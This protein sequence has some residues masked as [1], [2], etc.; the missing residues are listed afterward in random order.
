MA[1]QRRNRRGGIESRWHKTVY[2]TGP[3]G[4]KTKKQVKS[5]RYG[6]GK[7]WLARYVDDHGNEHTKSFDRKVDAQHWLDGQMSSLVHGNHVAPSAGRELIRDAG[8]RWLESQG[9]LKETTDSSRRFT[10]HIHVEPYWG[11]LAIRDVRKSDVKAWIA[12]MVRTGVGAPTIEK[13]A[14]VLRMI[15]ETAVEDQQR[16]HNPCAGVKLPRPLHKRRGYLTHDQ[17]EHLAKEVHQNPTMIRFLAYTGLRWGEMAA[18][19]GASFDTSRRRVMIL[20]AVAEVS[21][22]LVWSSTKGHT[23]RSVVLPRFLAD[24][25][26]PMIRNA[27]YDSLVFRTAQGAPLRGNNYRKRVFA[28]AVK[29]AQIAAK[30]ARAEELRHG[31]GVVTP[32]FPNVTPHDLRHTA[33]SLAISAGANVKAVQTMVGHK[34]ASLTLNTYADL[35]PDDLEAVADALHIAARGP[36]RNDTAD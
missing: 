28:P 18:L 30:E 10:W 21:G 13:A 1:R 31:G 7:R 3:D 14:G 20:D 9:H 19:K 23:R 35:F 8:K 29:R 12:D 25:M 26:E 33:V 11:S 34:S 4:R 32:E 5:A 22:R 2:E 6:I 16:A 27:G 17:V 15:M 24:E 36:L